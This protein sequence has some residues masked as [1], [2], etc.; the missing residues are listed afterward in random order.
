MALT[1][2]LSPVQADEGKLRLNFEQ[3]PAATLDGRQGGLTVDELLSVTPRSKSLNIDTDNVGP[4]G[5][6]LPQVRLGYDDEAFGVEYRL[7]TNIGGDTDRTG[8]SGL[9]SRGLGRG[10]SLN[11]DLSLSDA[12][13]DDG[14]LL[15]IGGR[16]GYGGF[17]VGADFGRE[18]RLRDQAEYRDY[19]LDLSYGGQNWRVGMQ[20]MRS[21]QSREES[22]LGVAD[23]LEFGGVYNLNRSIDLVGGVQFWDQQNLSDL[24]EQ[25]R[26]ALIF[27]GTRIQF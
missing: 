9:G 23:A 27:V 14:G 22:L 20:Y 12:A 5:R 19:R 1:A 13:G 18:S 6:D 26:D 25:S 8:I 21:L 24:D 3:A 11:D 10:I 16:L 4:S 17:S 2:F 15:Q 7:F